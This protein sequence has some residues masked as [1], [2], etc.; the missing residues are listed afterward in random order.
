MKKI[1]VTGASGFIGRHILPLLV[2]QGFEV[3]GLGRQARPEPEGWRQVVG[4]LLDTAFVE[5][6][7]ARER[8]SHLLH[9]AWIATPGTYWTSLEN[10][11]WVQASLGLV[12][13]FAAHGGRRLVGAGSCAEYD[14]RYGYFVEGLAPCRPATMYGRSKDGFRRLA[15]AYCAASG[16]SFA[17]GRIFYTFGPG[18]DYRRLAPSVVQS[19]LADRPVPCTHGQQVRDYLYVEDLAR[20]FVELTQSPVQGCVNMASGVPLA[21]AELVMALAKGVGRP[22]LV[23]LGE[24]PLAVDEPPLLVADVRRLRQDVGFFPSVG[25]QWAVARTVAFWKKQVVMP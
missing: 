20:A 4:D 2:S 3:I 18:E 11:A 5:G 15:E 22:D 7:M 17:W 13:A 24:I 23:R 16:L 8:F 21:V 19:L 1:L 12:R 6:L 9:L 14:W 10:L 25:L